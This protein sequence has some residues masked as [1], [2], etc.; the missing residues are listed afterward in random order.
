MDRPNCI[1]DL[2]TL[3]LSYHPLLVIE[4][5]EENR[6]RSLLRSVAAA[7][8]M[9]LFEWTLARG[10]ARLPGKTS[11]PRTVEPLQLLKHLK[12]MTLESI[13]HLKDFSTHL[14]DPMTVRLFREVAQG[15]ARTRST[16]VL[17][18]EDVVLPK[19]IEH[20]VVRYDICL[21]GPDELRKVVETVIRSL[22]AYQTIKVE[23][24]P[25]DM[26]G[27][28]QALAGMTLNQARQTVAYCALEDG[29]LSRDDIRLVLDRKAQ[30]FKDDGLLEYFPAEGNQFTLGGFGKLKGWLQR[31]R[32]GFSQEAR[33]INLAAPRGILI[34]GVQGCG[35]SLAAKVIA[36]E[37]GLP[38]LKLDAGRLFDKYIGESEKNFRKAISLA[39]SM[40]PAVL[41]IDEIEKGMAPT[42]SAEADAGLSRRLFGSFLTWLQ[43]KKESV[44]VVATAND[45]SIVPPELLRKGRFDEVFFVDLP[46]S[47]EREDILEIHL[48]LRKQ[49][50]DRFHLGKIVYATEGFSGAEIEQVI[51][52]ALYR[53][54]YLKRP[55]DTDL[56]IEEVHAT[57]PLSVTRKEDIQ[58]LRAT[59]QNRF[60]PV[61]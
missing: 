37:W 11:V 12:T 60:V 25:T 52:A 48:A 15:F 29:K 30:I 32:M 50:S 46:N 59:A 13:F 44:F 42:G 24:R 4:T 22:S 56:I 33:D 26:N 10:L 21:P 27:I 2:K 6:V 7:V 3:V 35:K 47:N 9:P 28:L 39:E 8:K 36:K 54:L 17:T 14:D 31:A 34:V 58:K 23:L 51:I 16:I 20:K 61:S 38:L 49:S 5:V 19:E 41:W 43:E 1:H 53:A 55:L 40:A 57:V 45:L 18:A